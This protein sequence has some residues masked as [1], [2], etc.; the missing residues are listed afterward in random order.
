M[1][2]K[3]SPPWITFAKEVTALFETDEEVK[4]LYDGVE[5]TITLFVDNAAKADALTALLPEQ[6]EFG[7]VAVKLIVKPSNDAR[8]GD[9]YEDTYKT[10]FDGND[11]LVSTATVVNPLGTFTYVVWD[12]QIVQFFA[13]N[14]GDIE[15]NESMLLAEVAA[16]VLA[17]AGGVYH[18]TVPID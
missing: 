8:T 13:D 16:D 2:L 1:K 9:A 6:K 14:L 18:C 15:G 4:V 12:A 11:A 10:A 17:P 3:L 7:N 5:Q